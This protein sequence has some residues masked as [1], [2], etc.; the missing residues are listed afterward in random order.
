MADKKKQKLTSDFEEIM[1]QINP[2]IT[3]VDVTDKVESIPSPSPSEPTCPNCKAMREALH[4]IY[5]LIDINRPYC[6]R[7]DDIRDIV[8]KF[9]GGS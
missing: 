4:R 3:F 7:C 1:K 6:D 5:E 2:N 9:E 8:M